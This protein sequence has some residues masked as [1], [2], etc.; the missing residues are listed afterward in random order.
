[1]PQYNLINTLENAMRFIYS[2]FLGND[3]T[4]EEFM[5]SRTYLRAD[6]RHAVRRVIYENIHCTTA[7]IAASEARFDHKVKETLPNTIA[8]SIRKSKARHTNKRG[9]EEIKK[10]FNQW[11]EYRHEFEMPGLKK[12]LE[13]LNGFPKSSLVVVL[14]TAVEFGH[15]KVELF[16]ALLTEFGSISDRFLE[17]TLKE[18][19]A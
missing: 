5:Q 2:H 1:M 7:D 17:E 10:L 19:A 11:N 18:Q 6:I 15:I 8:T 14:S 3:E 16:E 9:Y 12:R 13:Q 4:L